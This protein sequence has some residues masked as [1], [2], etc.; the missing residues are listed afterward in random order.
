[1]EYGILSVNIQIV[2]EKIIL[3]ITGILLCDDEILKMRQVI[4]SVD[5]YEQIGDF[6]QMQIG[7]H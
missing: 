2:I 1:M 4:L 3:F 6:Q 7:M 5:N